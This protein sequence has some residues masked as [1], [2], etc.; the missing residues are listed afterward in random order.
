M[1]VSCIDRKWD[2]LKCAYRDGKAC[3]H[4]VEVIRV[5][6]HDDD[7]RYDGVACPPNPEDFSQLL[8]V[9]GSCFPY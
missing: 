5:F 9:F 7:L 3:G 2:D 1:E 6:A 4:S 8:Q